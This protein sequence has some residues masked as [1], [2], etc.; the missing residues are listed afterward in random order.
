[1]KSSLS[2]VFCSLSV[3]GSHLT[4]LHFL[5]EAISRN[6]PVIRPP[7]TGD[8]SETSTSPVALQEQREI[9]IFPTVQVSNL[10]Q[11]EILVLLTEC[12]PGNATQSLALM[13]ENCLLIIFS[14]SCRSARN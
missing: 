5:I 1:M 14:V 3:E 13:E 9:F 8:A 6:V 2:T 7:N 10:L 11:S 4:N 12:H